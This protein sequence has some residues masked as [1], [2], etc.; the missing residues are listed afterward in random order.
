MKHCATESMMRAETSDYLSLLFSVP[1]PVPT[2]CKLD[3]AMKMLETYGRIAVKEATFEHKRKRNLVFLNVTRSSE[4]NNL[5][6]KLRN[7]IVQPM[8]DGYEFIVSKFRDK[9]FG[10][11]VMLG[12]GSFL[13]E[14]IDDKVFFKLPITR[15]DAKKMV[16]NTFLGKFV[17]RRLLADYLLKFSKVKS[18]VEIN[19][20]IV[21]ERVYAVDVRPV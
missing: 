7:P 20:L 4:L 2:T 16:D 9:V 11:I 13:A 14:S 5:W 21:G 15:K 18:Y 17:N 6:K 1:D 10:D 3:E 19:P 12:S 8:V